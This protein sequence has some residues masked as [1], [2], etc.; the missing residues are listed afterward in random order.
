MEKE[1][2][3]NRSEKMGLHAGIYALVYGVYTPAHCS[4][5]AVIVALLAL[6]GGVLVSYVRSE[7][8]PEWLRAGIILLLIV[9]L[10]GILL[11]YKARISKT[12]CFCAILLCSFVAGE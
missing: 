9:S 3:A 11:A 4:L 8:L 6:L 10:V 5:E 7:E 2:H 1:F 12:R